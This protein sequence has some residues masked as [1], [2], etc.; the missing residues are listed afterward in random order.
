MSATKGGFARREEEWTLQKDLADHELAQIGKQILAAE[1][2]EAI[3]ENEKSNHELQIE[4]AKEAGA[5]LREKYSS[6]ELY[7]WT[8]GQVSS[9]YFPSYQLAYDVAKRAE[10]AYRFELGLAPADSNFIQFGYWDTLKK[11]LLAGERLHLDLK[12]MDARYLEQNDREYEITKHISLA[13]LAPEELIALK[14]VGRCKFKGGD[15]L[16]SA[17]RAAVA[18]RLADEEAPPLSRMFSAQHEFPNEWHRFKADWALH[19]KSLATSTPSSAPELR[20]EIGARLP[21]FTRGQDVTISLDR[22]HFVLVGQSLMEL[23][24]VSESASIPV[25]TLDAT[26]GTRVTVE[27]ASV[28]VP[29]DP[30]TATDLLVV[31]PYRVSAGP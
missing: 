13:A 9:L 8:V 29:F 15:L 14:T 19:R 7:D 30:A 6:Q 25:V 21:Y 1:I 17:A 24:T 11:G 3:A 22:S 10:R 27:G 12:R 5:F 16:A 31:C 28:S 20:L 23:S 2:R 4:N 26:S 18:Q